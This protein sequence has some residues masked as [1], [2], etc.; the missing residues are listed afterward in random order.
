[1]KPIIG[2]TGCYQIFQSPLFH[3][4]ERFFI[5][6][7]YL[8]AI[9]DSGG[10]PLPI[11]VLSCPDEMKVYLD[12]CDGLLLPGGDD[13]DPQYFGEDPHLR[14][15]TV[16][17]EIDKYELEIIKIAL[18]KKMPM[19]GICRGEQMINVAKGGSIHQD[20]HECS[21]LKTILHQQR[22]DAS[23][24][25]H[26]VSV[27]PGTL[28]NE[29][30][31]SLEV[32]T[33]TMHHQAVNKPGEGLIISAVAPDGIIEAIESEDRLIIGVQWHPEL[34]AKSS[35]PMKKLFEHFI[36]TMAVKYKNSAK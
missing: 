8:S 3:T 12:M 5:N 11:P 18:E 33:N 9:T 16:R 4:V 27:T 24:G 31:G 14:L 32:R 36:G 35:P 30:F 17:P 34:M 15:G 6:R 2:V 1:M 29:I 21:G 28:L 20:I 26:K 23:M 25:I 19:L 22:Y 13:V 7:P 10:L